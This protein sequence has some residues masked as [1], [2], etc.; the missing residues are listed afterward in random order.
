MLGWLKNT[1]LDLF[2]PTFCCG[3]RRWGPFLCRNCLEHVEYLPIQLSIH[4]HLSECFLDSLSAATRH[5]FPISPLIHALKY[6]HVKDIG[7]YCGQL[8]YLHATLPQVEVITS[9]PLHK[10]RLSE[11][12]FNQAAEIAQELSRLTRI[13]YLP[14]LLRTRAT[15]HQAATSERS[16]RLSNLVD[17]FTICPSS[18]TTHTSGSPRAPPTTPQVPSRILLIDDVTTTGTTLNECARI[19]KKAGALEVHGL[20][21][22]H[23]G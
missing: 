14:L 13:P 2:F 1:L 18:A 5:S 22:A 20:T 7:A 10:H 23:G 3:C 17:S 8:L 19:L 11:R 4:R 9:V 16:E 15:P 21:V 12:G 6:D